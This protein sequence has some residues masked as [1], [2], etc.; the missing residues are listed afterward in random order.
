MLQRIDK[1]STVE[2]YSA[3]LGVNTDKLVVKENCIVLPAKATFEY[4]ITS[5]NSSN[6]SKGSPP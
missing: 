5:F 6:S 1:L 4:S 3:I 2:K